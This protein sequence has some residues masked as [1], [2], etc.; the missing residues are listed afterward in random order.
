MASSHPLTQEDKMQTQGR[1]DFYASLNE[2]FN[3]MNFVEFN[4]QGSEFDD[5]TA[6]ASQSGIASQ[7][8]NAYFS[9]QM[10]SQDQHSVPDIPTDHLNFRETLEDDLQYNRKEL[11]QH[12]CRFERELLL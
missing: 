9:S 7:M 6:T 2:D 1:D 10:A 3:G 11:P 5:Y 4:T 8:S 12:A